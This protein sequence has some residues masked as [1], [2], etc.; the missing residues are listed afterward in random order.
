VTRA[1]T[2]APNAARHVPDPGSSAASL[3][4]FTQSEGRSNESSAW[5]PAVRPIAR[6]EDPEETLP[7]KIGDGEE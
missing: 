7:R 5:I 6:E 3:S 1:A 2:E 4:R